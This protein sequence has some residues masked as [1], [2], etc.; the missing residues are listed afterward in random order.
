MESLI[1]PVC[2]FSNDKFMIECELCDAI[3]PILPSALPT[4][5][6]NPF[7]AILHIDVKSTNITDGG[8]VC[9]VCTF[10]N[11]ELMVDCE[12]C[13]AS[14]IKSTS[15]RNKISNVNITKYND[16]DLK[17]IEQ[18]RLLDKIVLVDIHNPNPDHKQ[19]NTM[20]GRKL[21]GNGTGY[22]GGNSKFD[23]R[24]IAQAVAKT[25][26]QD[27][28]IVRIFVQLETIINNSI[29]NNTLDHTLTLLSSSEGLKLKICNLLRNE[30][31]VDIGSRA[32]LYKQ[33]LK[34]LQVVSKEVL[35]SPFLEIRLNYEKNNI[36]NN[37]KLNSST[38]DDDDDD[39][40]NNDNSK[41]KEESDSTCFS[42]LSS[43]SSLAD[44]F[45]KLASDN[46][47]DED[48]KGA[49]EIA[50]LIS[51]VHSNAERAKLIAEKLFNKS[52]SS[53]STTTTTTTTTSADAKEKE[54]VAMMQDKV[55][56][57]VPII[58]LV[59]S[60]VI[61]HHFV[62]SPIT[63]K[64]LD[65]N[66]IMTEI[67]G[68]SKSLPV[69]Y[70]SSII[71]RCDETQINV[72]KALIIG[73]VDTPYENGVF[74]F[75]ILL[76]YDYPNVPPKI[77]L[78]TTGN[79]T[80]R[81]NPNL[82]NCGKVCLSLLGTW[83]GP[84]W[85]SKHS[86][87]L[88][89]LVSIQSLILVNDPFFNEPGCEKMMHSAQG[90]Q[91]SANYNKKIQIATVTFAMI[92]ALRSPSPIFQD[93]I[94]EHF[95]FKASEIINKVNFWSVNNNPNLKSQIPELQSLLQSLTISRK[96]DRDCI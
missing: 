35:I 21:K 3:L 32:I 87:L 90:N 91:A 93:V 61:S 70:G 44:L 49:M 23:G 81:F 83:T 89:V 20:K 56:D 42:L 17:L 43:L 13:S 14:L 4:H 22:G 95:R 28:E 74:E 65:T 27:E 69:F 73:P 41:D 54:Y 67:V 53:S 6:A 50:F 5:S 51:S 94:R 52:S 2:S 80:V 8:L 34:F 64:V 10:S 12:I 37:Y 48:L 92:Q 68:L 72:L 59:R 30:S 79:G 24:L 26:S 31:L 25:Q 58:E 76:P 47:E 39:D 57:S 38:W 19:P 82:Y 96:R 40:E 46:I 16:N 77:N 60:K 84:S 63:E 15:V 78:C 66:R 18:L 45:L 88:Q 85:N 86:T 71:V 9:P 29:E 75:D 1:C 55:F 62:T 36:R 11:N 7:D 33:L